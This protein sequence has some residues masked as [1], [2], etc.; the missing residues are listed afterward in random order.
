MNDAL[1]PQG[2]LL[3]IFVVLDICIDCLAD[4]FCSF[5]SVLFNPFAILFFLALLFLLL[6]AIQISVLMSTEEIKG[7]A[8]NLP[9]GVKL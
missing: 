7:K 4:Q 6:S 1:S 9:H 3:E 5:R 8:G 2:K